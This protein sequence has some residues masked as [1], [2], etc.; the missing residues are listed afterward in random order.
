MLLLGDCIGIGGMW[1][2]LRRRRRRS[3]QLLLTMMSL[4][5]DRMMIGHR[6]RCDG[7]RRGLM[8]LLEIGQHAVGGVGGRGRR[9]R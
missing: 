1:R 3:M 5:R 2:E 6:R 4:R 8:R 9:Q 7:G